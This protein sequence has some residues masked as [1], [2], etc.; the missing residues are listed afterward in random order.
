MMPH[1]WCFFNIRFPCTPE[2]HF[3]NLWGYGYAAPKWGWLHP[4]KRLSPFIV[5]KNL[6]LKIM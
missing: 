3:V 4:L 2:I 6:T 1:L 5:T